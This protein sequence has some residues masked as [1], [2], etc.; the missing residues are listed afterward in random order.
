MPIDFHDKSNY[1][2][3]TTR[4]AEDRWLE[5]IKQFVEIEQ[6]V[7]LDLGCGGGIYS[8]ALALSG[9]EQVIAMDF[10]VE[11]LKGA[12][13]NCKGIP[14][15]LF[16]EG[17]A[18]NSGL[19]SD[20][21]DVLLERAVIHHIQD[22]ESCFNEAYRVLKP[23]G[24]FIIQDR[25]PEDCMLPGSSQHIRGYFFEKFPRL[26]E[27]ETQRRFTSDQVL[28]TLSKSGFKLVEEI[29][30]WETRKHYE[31]VEQLKVDLLNRTGRSILHELT[32]N[33]LQELVDYIMSNLD[34]QKNIKEED[35]WT[36]WI[37]EK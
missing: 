27:K 31:N 9:A 25:T 3:Y 12:K 6:K 24:K 16:M 37:A 19:K 18:L 29:R 4:N 13:E 34:G 28:T 10:S 20:K 5:I 1:L 14:N 2:S 17:N 33:E 15:I 30:Y 36:I 7:V 8:K 23:G 22:L 21:V 11:M 26:L 35:R 32:N